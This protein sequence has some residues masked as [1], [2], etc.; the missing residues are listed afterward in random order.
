MVERGAGEQGGVFD[1]SG[2]RADLI[3]AR[4]ES[5][6]PI[7]RTAAVGWFEAHHSAHG[8]GLPDGASSVGSQSKRS[9]SGGYGRGGSAGAA[10]GC[11]A[12]VPRVP[13]RAVG[14]GLGARA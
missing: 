11:S 2:K 6:E 9:A 1:R 7:A 4:P 13:G 8:G 3:Q 14:G 5:N 12:R 10:S